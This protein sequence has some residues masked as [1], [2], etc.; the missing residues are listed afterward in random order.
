[1]TLPFFSRSRKPPAFVL[2]VV[3]LHSQAHH[4]THA[5]E[6]E[7]HDRDQGAIAQADDAR[8]VHAVE[9]LSSFRGRDDGRRPFRDR[10]ARPADGV[11]GIRRHD[12]TGYQ[13]IEQHADASQMLFDSRSGTDRAQLLDVTRHMHRVH[14][15]NP[16]NAPVFAPAE[17]R[18]R[19]LSISGAGIFVA[20]VD[21]KEFQKAPGSSLS[22]IGNQEPGRT[23]RRKVLR[24]RAQLPV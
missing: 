11:G 1:L 8:S 16:G 21:R 18:A 15:L 20:D 17:E 19:S 5:G 23:R 10:V 14:V 3:V 7:R 2:R 4:R 13:P 9:Q 6:R 12:L 22:G 24:E